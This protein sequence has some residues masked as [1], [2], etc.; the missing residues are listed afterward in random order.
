M[1][2]HKRWQLQLLDDVGNGE[3]FAGAGCAKQHLVA[4]ALFDACDQFFNCLRLISGGFVGGM[5][6][7]FHFLIVLVLA[8]FSSPE[9]AW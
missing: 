8:P 2:H 6:F 3:G 1:G 9:W 5:K 4:V 7:E